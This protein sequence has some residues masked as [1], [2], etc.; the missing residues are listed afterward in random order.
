MKL[1]RIHIKSAGKYKLLNNFN[2][3][4]YTGSNEPLQSICLVG[5]N[6]S[7]KSQLL[8]VLAD[9]FYSLDGYYNLFNPRKFE[10]DVLFEI[11]Y[12]IGYNGENQTVRI[13]RLK[14]SAPE[15]CL[16][17][18]SE[19]KEIK[20]KKI[21]AHILPKKIVG[22]TSGENETLSIPFL[23]AYDEYASYVA[24][25]ALA[26]DSVAYEKV[27]DTRLVLLNYNSNIS[28]FVAN[29][30]LR[31]DDD[32][33]IFSEQ[34]N[35]NHL[36][37]FRLIIQLKRKTPL[38]GIELTP[39]LESYLDSLKKCA[40]C[41][42]FQPNEHIYTFDYFVNNETK[43]AFKHFF[44]NAFRLYSAFY[45]LE[46]LNNL[47]IEKKQRQRIKKLR[48]EHKFVVKPPVIPEENK[49]FRFENV[50]LEIKQSP[51]PIDYI[52]LSDGEHQFVQIFGSLM[53]IEDQGTLFLL[54]EPESHFNPTWRIRF[55][56]ILNMLSGSGYKSFV[57]TSHSPYIL[58]DC[59]R[60]NV[61]IFDLDPDKEGIAIR[62][63]DEETYGASFDRLLKVAFN[64]KTPVALKS[65][66]EIR[67]LQKSEDLENIEKGIFKFGDSIEK[68][69]LFQRIGELNEQ[70]EKK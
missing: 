34:I 26:P 25:L 16:I 14:K 24:K 23:D 19:E 22:Y 20:D 37:S 52:S 68:F 9:I 21:I 40:T 3:S 12:T 5:I 69:Y 8:E 38:K 42:D 41:Y 49:V 54:D 2:Q 51:D 36:K 6:G 64:I 58:S 39:E 18:G 47:I 17:M 56:S 10:T 53:M 48:V 7:G 28:I 1:N 46:L 60:E 59:H 61:F 66:D 11:E 15:V 44:K 63:P 50:K 32:L 55:M 62:Q 65:L 27:P 70:K 4:F 45:K 33:N 30:L 57:I 31:N 29:F 67:K 13:S 35:I 43:S